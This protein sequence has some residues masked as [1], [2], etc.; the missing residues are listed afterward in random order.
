M[1][2]HCWPSDSSCPLL[3]AEQKLIA[4]RSARQLRLQGCR[5]GGSSCQGLQFAL[6]DQAKQWADGVRLRELRSPPSAPTDTRQLLPPPPPLPRQP[7][8]PCSLVLPS[9]PALQ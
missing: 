6:L 2:P 9:H 1:Q 5:L 3:C 7:C 8:R 4:A